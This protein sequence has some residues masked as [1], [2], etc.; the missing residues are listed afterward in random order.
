MRNLLYFP[1][2]HPKIQNLFSCSEMFKI[3]NY[4]SQNN[5]NLKLNFPCIGKKTHTKKL[6]F[7]TSK[8]ITLHFI[9]NLINKYAHVGS[10]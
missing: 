9:L 7:I 3:S 6:Y 2:F 4:I 1:K 10:E 8:C 5:K